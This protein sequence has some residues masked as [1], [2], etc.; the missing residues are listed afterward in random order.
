MALDWQEEMDLLWLN[1]PQGQ[2]WAQLE[3]CHQMKKNVEAAE[4][5]AAELWNMKQDSTRC[6]LARWH[7]ED[8][9]QAP[10]GAALLQSGR[11]QRRRRLAC[12]QTE[13]SAGAAKAAVARD[14][15]QDS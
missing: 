13:V 8:L 1:I 12:L 3:A 9:L 7:P 11:N 5:E 4:A 15:A 14:M 6:W 10:E 2:A